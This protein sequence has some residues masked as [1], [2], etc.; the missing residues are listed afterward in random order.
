[1]VAEEDRPGTSLERAEADET[2]AA[3]DVEKG[4]AGPE[5]GVVEDVVSPSD[6]T[7]EPAP[8]LVVFPARS[9]RCEPG[10]PA[11]GRRHA[12]ED[13]IA[14]R[15]VNALRQREVAV[16]GAPLDLGAGRRGVDMGPSAM[17]YAGLEER[18]TSLG[19]DVRDHGNVETAVPEA[20]A[21]Q[22]E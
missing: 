5:I 11:I 18:L 15:A 17:R 16:I 20:T 10:R 13:R 7:L 19:Y 9:E 12:P 1:D 4:L 6:E 14:F 22:D 2:L 21:L 3:A 8:A